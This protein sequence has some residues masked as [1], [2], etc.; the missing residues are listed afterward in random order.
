MIQT[1]EAVRALEEGVLTDI[2]EGDVGAILGWGFMPWSGGPFAWLDILGS[3]QALRHRRRARRR[4]RRALRPTRPAPRAGG[5]R[6]ELLR[7]LRPGRA[8]GLTGGRGRRRA[9]MGYPTRLPAA[10]RRRSADAGGKSMAM[11]RPPS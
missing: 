1:L 6:R 4:A 2:R 8:S 3:G 10:A 7:T 11:P 9:A 5:P